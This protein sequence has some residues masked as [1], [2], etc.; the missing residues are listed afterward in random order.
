MIR[1]LFVL[2]APHCTPHVIH[3]FNSPTQPYPT[4][5]MDGGFIASCKKLKN[6]L[7][8]YFSDYYKFAFIHRL[9]RQEL[10]PDPAVSA[11]FLHPPLWT[12]ILCSHGCAS[13]R[14]N[15]ILYPTCL[16]VL[17]CLPQPS[18]ASGTYAH[19]ATIL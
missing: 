15:F 11:G 16:G 3:V 14:G 19:A 4:M 7:S 12:S 13:S 5:E 1:R 10:C 2:H 9:C 6:I 17:L 18:P 8:V